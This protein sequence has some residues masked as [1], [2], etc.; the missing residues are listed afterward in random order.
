MLVLA[1]SP[2]EAFV[3]DSQLVVEEDD[4]TLDCHI[5]GS[6]LADPDRWSG[7]GLCRIDRPSGLVQVS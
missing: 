1:T 7:S 3:M 5:Q 2:V 4:H 6:N